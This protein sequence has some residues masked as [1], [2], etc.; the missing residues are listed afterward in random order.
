M[1]RIKNKRVQKKYFSC[2]L[3]N[4]SKTLKSETIGVVNQKHLQIFASHI[5]SF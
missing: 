4:S 3:L 5:L 1:L 2:T